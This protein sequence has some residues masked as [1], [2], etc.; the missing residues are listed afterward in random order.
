[1]NATKPET[2]KFRRYLGYDCNSWDGFNNGRYEDDEAITAAS[3][4]D[5]VKLCL[6]TL[7][8]YLGRKLGEEEWEDISHGDGPCIQVTTRYVD[9]AGDEISAEKFSDLNEDKEC[10]G[11]LYVY[12]SAEVA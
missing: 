4:D 8:A 2:M 3:Y 6:E 9:D 7:E 5:A 1:M 11:Y 10:G 12:V